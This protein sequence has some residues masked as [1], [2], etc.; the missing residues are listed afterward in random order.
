MNPRVVTPL[1]AIGLQQPS[2]TGPFLAC[3]RRSCLLCQ[4]CLEALNIKIEAFDSETESLT[5]FET[6][7]MCLKVTQ[8]IVEV[9]QSN[10]CYRMIFP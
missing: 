2:T 8:S 10:N 5:C 3:I 6:V 7:R 4:L 1:F 9:V